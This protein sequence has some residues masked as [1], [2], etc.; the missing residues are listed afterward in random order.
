MGIN[1]TFKGL[2]VYERHL[3][4]QQHVFKYVWTLYEKV[5]CLLDYISYE[6]VKK[7]YK[8]WQ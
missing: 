7:I 5:Y 2:I 3:Q 4:Q 6:D 1:S 8:I